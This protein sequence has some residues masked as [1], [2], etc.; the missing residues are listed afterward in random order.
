MARLPRLSLAGQMHCVRQRGNNGQF[1][2][3]SEA[4]FQRML[5]ALYHYARQYQ[6]KVHAYVLA[7]DQFQLLLTPDL[8]NG[9][10]PFMQAIGRSYVRYFNAAHGRTGTLWE[11]RYRST[12]VDAQHFA[13]PC[14]I[15]MDLLAQT[16]GHVP[17]EDGGLHSSFGHYAG[18]HVNRLIHVPAQ[19]WALGNTPF[20]REAAYVD[21]V[22]QGLSPVQSSAIARALQGGWVLGDPDFVAGLQKITPRRLH[23]RKPGR[24][25]LQRQAD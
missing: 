23:P 4:D 18:T 10:S 3:E 17:Q 14:M 21:L 1:I 20:D 9:V 19:Y 2:F 8:D 6:V 5:D 15:A 24:P 7:K 16:G 22:H 13:L 25:N 11:G 12:I